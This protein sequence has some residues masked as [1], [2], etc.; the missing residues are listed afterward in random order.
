[1]HFVIY[2]RSLNHIL[3]KLL[4]SFFTELVIT[5]FRKPGAD[6]RFPWSLVPRK[7][8]SYSG[9]KFHLIFAL[10][11]KCCSSLDLSYLC[12]L[13]YMPVGSHFLPEHTVVSMYNKY[14]LCP[15]IGLKIILYINVN[16]TT[17]SKSY[18]T[19]S[20]VKQSFFLFFCHVVWLFYKQMHYFLILQT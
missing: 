15:L 14:Q 17:R 20:L 5:G 19:F 9:Y 3:T 4:F 6:W 8:K 16:F 7:W 2:G 13:C 12:R 1:M 18:E 11:F 10:S